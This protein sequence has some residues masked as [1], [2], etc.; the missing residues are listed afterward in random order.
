MKKISVDVEKINY[1]YRKGISERK[2][3][4]TMNVSRSTI[5]NRVYNLHYNIGDKRRFT[6]NKRFFQQPNNINSYWAGF[7]AAD[8]CV[9]YNN[10]SLEIHK[11]DIKHLQKLCSVLCF[12]GTINERKTRET[13][14]V[15]IINDYIVEDLLKNFNITPRKAKTL[16]PPNISK[17]ENIRS[18]IRGY[19]D[20][21]GSYS[22]KYNNMTA[23]GTKEVLQWIKNCLNNFGTINTQT[24][25]LYDTGSFK[26][27]IQGKNKYTNTIKWLFKNAYDFT[28]LDR[29]Y[30]LVKNLVKINKLNVEWIEQKDYNLIRENIINERIKGRKKKDIAKENDVSIVF[31]SNVL[32]Q[33]NMNHL[34]K[35]RLSR[36]D[37]ENIINDLKEYTF[38]EVAEKYGVNVS[39]ICEVDAGRTRI[40]KEVKEKMKNDRSSNEG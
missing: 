18:F 33:N 29:K 27:Q 13:A 38:Y 31:V 14:S 39:T 36:N 37:V 16:I 9:H 12:N 26:L 8:G 7:L 10:L 2:I 35:N 21:D 3:A 40:S 17:E 32:K 22:P 25:I 1:L 15:H 4:E 30:E 34:D 11:K 24:T 19:I 23:R 20:G 5:R 6:L 28:I